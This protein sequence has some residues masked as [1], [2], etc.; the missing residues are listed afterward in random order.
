MLLAQ[1]SS[2]RVVRTTAPTEL[3]ASV[4]S[5]PSQLKRWSPEDLLIKYP[6]GKVAD[7]HWSLAASGKRLTLALGRSKLEELRDALG[8]LDQGEDDF[9]IAPEGE[10]TPK[11]QHLWFW[12]PADRR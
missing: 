12:L 10:K 2:E 5:V 11:D 4:L 8:Q 3:I 7:T 1:W 9:C 6:K